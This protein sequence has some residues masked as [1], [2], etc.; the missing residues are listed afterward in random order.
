MGISYSNYSNNS[1]VPDTQPWNSKIDRLF[2]T[3]IIKFVIIVLA[4]LS[5]YWEHYSNRVNYRTF[6]GNSM[7]LELKITWVKNFDPLT[8]P[9]KKQKIVSHRD[10]N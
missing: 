5:D 3:S 8:L 1:I 4:T 10:L 7:S 6:L 2:I 9:A